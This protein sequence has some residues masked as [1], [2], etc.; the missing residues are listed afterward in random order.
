MLTQTSTPI[1]VA[2]LDAALTGSAF[3]PGDDAY[4]E[5]RTG[6]VTMLDHRPAV[7]ALP[8]TAE[9]IAAVVAFARSYGL[10]VAPQGTGHNG[11]PLG[12]LEDAVLLKTG[13]MRGVAIDAERKVARVEAGAW[14]FDV[15]EAAHEHGLTPLLG[16]SPDVGVVGYTLGAG[17][18]WMARKHG[19]ATNNVA[20][21]EVVTPEGRLVRADHVNE[22][23]LFWALR[24]GG[25]NFGVVTA[26]EIRL[27]DLETAYAGVMLFPVERAAEVLKAWVA[28]TQDA[29]DEV[30]SIG[31]ILNVPPL[32][33]VPEMLR[34]RSFARIEAVFLGSEEDGVELLRPLR[35]LGPEMDLFGMQSSIEISRLHMDPEGS[36][37]LAMSDHQLI[38]RIDDAGIDRLVEIA[39]AGS[40]SPLVMLEL[41]HAGGA[42]GRSGPD[43]GV[44]DVL[45]GEFLAFALGIPMAPEMAA[46][47]ET[48]LGV[49]RS[50]L[51][52][53]D[54]NRAYM[55]FVER[56]A[57]PAAFFGEEAY[58]RL[59]AIKAAVDPGEM[60]R[61]NHPIRPA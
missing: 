7:V 4:D 33:E 6:W 16:S 57:D 34:G 36:V 54:T 38:E 1:D 51:A 11:Y 30:T 35:E 40:G 27:F 28:W 46:A 48:D 49:V 15:V 44:A 5:A 8:E 9:D 58:A 52:G 31:S 37:P 14:M 24:G 22:P 18:S 10:R 61:A 32:P 59:R 17:V 25:G 53:Y 43:H 47:I 42:L 45:P 60:L 55:N 19:L 3:A 23:D 26:M 39:G 29:P 21:I 12:G 13:R 50:I 41:R 20:A 56:E 2:A